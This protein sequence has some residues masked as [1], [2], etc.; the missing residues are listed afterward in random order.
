MKR[1]HFLRGLGGATLALPFLESAWRSAHAAPAISAKRLVILFQMSGVNMD[2]FALSGPFGQL[3]A[4][5][6]AGDRSLAA[7]APYRDRL[8]VARGIGT[9]PG[10]P[11]PSFHDDS[12]AKSLSATHRQG[13]LGGGITVDQEAAKSLNANTSRKNPLTL[14]CHQDGSAYGVQGVISYV[15][16]GQPIA[17]E[18]NP[19]KALGDLGL[20]SADD[21]TKAMA[22]ARRLS[23]IDLVSEEAA[24]LKRRGL[25]K[26][27]QDKLDFHYTTLRASEK[28]ASAACQLPAQVQSDW[29]RYEPSRAGEDGQYRLT[30]ELQLNIMAMALACGVSNVASMMWTA[31]SNGPGPEMDWDGASF[32]R[33]PHALSH[34][35]SG[36]AFANLAD[37]DVMRK[38]ATVDAWYAKRMLQLLDLLDAYREVDGSVLDN[39][40]VLWINE[41]SDGGS[42]S[43]N[44]VPIVIAGRAGGALKTGQYVNLA[45]A[46]PE[47]FHENGAFKGNLIAGQHCVPQS[48][49]FTTLLNALGATQNGAPY[50]RFGDVSLPNAEYTALRR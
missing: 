24:Q 6:F 28:A 18:N 39:S 38:I 9:G 4:A 29:G 34:G 12:I 7:L 33:N 8:I 40:A 47:A 48:R 37:P 19:Q 1:R 35:V 17:S 2:R 49:L 50:E 32:E 16:P 15:G 36:G 42:H 30:A 5:H 13:E 10:T 22:A 43:T 26:A 23:V 45:T 14:A 46:E 11:G 20:N 41:M 27:D 3:E 44:D 21:A 25:S 31:G